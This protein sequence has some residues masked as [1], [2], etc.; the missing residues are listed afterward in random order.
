MTGRRQGSGTRQAR[1]EGGERAQAAHRTKQFRAPSTHLHVMVVVVA[2]L[3]EV[4]AAP[5]WRRR[6]PLV[7]IPQARLAAH[8]PQAQRRGQPC[9]PAAAGAAGAGGGAP[10]H[11]VGGSQQGA[12]GW[13]A[14]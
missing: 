1:K 13:Q 8:A 12:V 10:V 3:H 11:R 9:S 14:Q 5:E 7:H 6:Q 2:A 4:H